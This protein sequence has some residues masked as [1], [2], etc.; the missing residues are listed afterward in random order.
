[1]EKVRAEPISNQLHSYIEYDTKEWI[2][3]AYTKKFK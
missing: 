3:G 1:M 2:Y